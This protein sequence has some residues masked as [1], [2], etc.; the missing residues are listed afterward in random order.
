MT[1]PHWPTGFNPTTA[2][3]YT[4]NDI[5][6]TRSAEELWPLLIGA[7]RWPEWYSRSSE[8]RLED[9]TDQLRADSLFSWKTLGVAVT[10]RVTG[11]DPARFLAWEG[12]GP[13][14]R[15]YHRWIFEPT[16]GGGCRVITEEIQVGP[17]PRLLRRRLRRDLLVFHQEWLEGL[18]A[19]RAD[20]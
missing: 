13:G 14:S 18:V 19:R 9:G 6:T 1:T 3:V 8:V 12:S 11:F 2:P 16:E 15:G 20:S 7:V 17:V 5:A 10:T 4:R